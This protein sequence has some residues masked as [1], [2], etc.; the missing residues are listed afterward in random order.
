[1]DRKL[2]A[3]KA[4]SVMLALAFMVPI[5]AIFAGEAEA[6]YSDLTAASKY[7]PN[8]QEHY[9][10]TRLYFHNTG[11]LIDIQGID[12]NMQPT[13]IMQTNR[14]MNTT[15]PPQ[16]D[17]PQTPQVDSHF[18]IFNG[19][20]QSDN[21]SFYLD[22]GISDGMNIVGGDLGIY[23]SFDLLSLA[24]GTF[25]DYILSM[26]EKT[27]F[28]VQLVDVAPD[29]TTTNITEWI[30]SEVS[31][32]VL[33]LLGAT[34]VEFDL[35][36]MDYDI[37]AGHVIKVMIR[38]YMYL[39][40]IVGVGVPNISW[41]ILYD[42]ADTPSHIDLTASALKTNVWTEDK[43][44]N[45]EEDF[46][47]SGSSDERR[48]ITKLLIS[49]VFSGDNINSASVKIYNS[50]DEDITSN[51]SLS[52]AESATVPGLYTYVW[53][54][55]DDRE[56][57][58]YYAKIKITTAL[59]S[60][61]VTKSFSIGTFNFLLTGEDWIHE[62]MPGQST[63]FTF[64]IKNSG[65]SPDTFAISRT[66]EGTWSIVS[67]L[68][69]T[70]IS[71]E[72]GQSQN[73]TITVAAPSTAM[74][75]D[76]ATIVVSALSEETSAER[77]VTVYGEVSTTR[78]YGVEVSCISPSKNLRPGGSLL[79]PVS[80]RNTGNAKDTFAID[81]A[82]LSD[83]IEEA[84][85]SKWTA[86]V[87]SPSIEILASSTVVVIVNLAAPDSP[88]AKGGEIIKVNF[89]ATSYG[90][91]ANSDWMAL[92]G[93]I[94]FAYDFETNVFD[95]THTINQWSDSSHSHYTDQSW[96]R[97]TINNTGDGDDTYTIWKTFSANEW[98]QYE[99]PAI[100][101]E[102]QYIQIY[103]VS[104]TNENTNAWNI[105]DI[106]P[107]QVTIPAHGFGEVIFKVVSSYTYTDVG[108]FGEWNIHV[109]SAH[110]PLNH[111]VN[112]VRCEV[113]SAQKTGV[114]AEWRYK[115]ATSKLV[116]LTQRNMTVAPGSADIV[117]GLVKPNEK[118]NYTIR[119]TNIG[120]RCDDFKVTSSTMSGTASST[121]PVTLNAKTKAQQPLSIGMGGTG[122]EEQ[123][124]DNQYKEAEIK[125]EIT[126]PPDAQVGETAIYDIF[127]V[128]ARDASKSI[129]LRC[130]SKVV[131]EYGLEASVSPA[132][133]GIHEG[134][135]AQYTVIIKNTG[136]G[137]DVFNVSIDP[138]SVI[139][140]GWTATVGDAG[141]VLL[142]IS[143]NSVYTSIL[144][145]S[146]PS[147]AA[148]G[149]KASVVL[150]IVSQEDPSIVETIAVDTTIMDDVPGIEISSNKDSDAVVSGRETQ[151][152]ITVKNTQTVDD[153]VKIT[154]S[155]PPAGWTVE[156]EGN[157]TGNPMEAL[158]EI[159]AGETKTIKLNVSSDEDALARTVVS[160]IV[161][162][163]STTNPA[164]F[165]SV[166]VRTTVTG[167]VQVGLTVEQETIYIDAGRTVELKVR[168]YNDGTD[169]DTITLTRTS[170]LQPGWNALFSVPSGIITIP[171]KSSREMTIAVSAPSAAAAG[172]QHYFTIKATSSANPAIYDTVSFKAVVAFRAVDISA[173]AA[174]MRIAPGESATYGLNA[175]N[176]GTSKEQ[177]DVFVM[178]GV[179][180][181]WTATLDKQSAIIDPNASS[182]V[183]LTVTAPASAQ[184]G[185]TATIVV[186]AA[187][188]SDSAAYETVVLTAKVMSYVAADVDDDGYPEMAIERDENATDGFES[189]KDAYTDGKL[190]APLAVVDGD[191]DD[192]KDFMLDTDGDETADTYWDPDNEIITPLT[193]LVDT[194]GDGTSEA[195]V[196]TDGDGKVDSIYY[197]EGAKLEPVALIDVDN[198]GK[199]EYL[200]DEDGDGIYDMYH[201]PQG[202][203]GNY[204]PVYYDEKSKTYTATKPS[205]ASPAEKLLD[206]IKQAIMDYWYLLVLCALVVVLAIVVVGSRR[207]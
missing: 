35:G 8:Y 79:F 196:D 143:G 87:G 23:V 21:A 42:N 10:E 50:D 161:R 68:S 120:T 114:S 84:N 3:S 72:P 85:I 186:K 106:S 129:S 65:G 76:E 151:Y 93:T 70:S 73:F 41:S 197:P 187:S 54:Y 167:M 190:S 52:S 57:G 105:Q 78:K 4:I 107:S 159:A 179:P 163:E 81:M 203:D 152:T 135:E 150:K 139:P 34:Y 127:M 181:G 108:D 62:V 56:T 43:D 160:T 103:W 184:S 175:I 131:Q 155:A 44:G 206:A 133:Q 7:G 31:P 192:K 80:I 74:N 166:S 20:T 205:E 157:I 1:M 132:S 64:N 53:S 95:A 130:I 180:S 109:Q 102:D 200:V 13:M 147:A 172:F 22:K 138:S 173:E 189:F 182:G 112:K 40:P 188:H 194:D 82:L 39:F 202:A 55:A 177:I 193:E 47:S 124:G 96:Y 169:E 92:I 45:I 146:A 195:F 32:N 18:V 183:M 46:V 90:S 49:D 176:N 66:I 153:I 111:E 144:K 29:N 36:A 101:I 97:L 12:E 164:I 5:G 37:P 171:A 51:G 98:G 86:S 89:T 88:F 24:T 110:N 59:Q 91:S 123:G 2:F 113:S 104:H 201:D 19:M 77:T 16:S 75:G 134:E 199:K 165:A 99:I 178:P 126:C 94:Y 63:Q 119:L 145:V 15:A 60:V 154:A 148:V 170:S 162:A 191:G 27:D 33:S 38:C 128:S 11:D 17:L 122:N 69:L 149:A 117:Y 6:A 185:S 67:D 116:G 48:V 140:N 14:T 30:A 158:L 174:E 204:D 142:P 71:L 26:I 100:G 58:V 61:D 83:N 9:V 28:E 121:W 141:Y 198:D 156:L 118:I 137:E 125:I 207:K 168:I 25:L 115:N 136:N